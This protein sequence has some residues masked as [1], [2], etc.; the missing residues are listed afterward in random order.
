MSRKKSGVC[1]FSNTK[2][3]N[4]FKEFFC[5]TVS[6][7]GGLGHGVVISPVSDKFVISHDEMSSPV[8]SLR[9]GMSVLQTPGYTKGIRFRGRGT[10]YPEKL[11][12]SMKLFKAGW[13]SEQAGIVEGA[14]T[15]L[16]LLPTVPSSINRSV[17]LR[18]QLAETSGPSAHCCC[19]TQSTPQAAELPP[20]SKTSCF[21]F[22]PSTFLRVWCRCGIQHLQGRR[23][24]SAVISKL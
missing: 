2:A 22:S 21:S 7:R 16:S 15:R 23:H 13:D 19:G 10:D 3:E 9:P 24:C 14:G 1:E 5:Y 6:T 12:A 20:D 17:I 11:C 18:E 4:L 8:L